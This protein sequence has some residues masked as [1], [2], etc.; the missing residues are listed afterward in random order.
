MLPHE[1]N[2]PKLSD[3][4]DYIRRAVDAGIDM[5]Q[6]RERDLAARDLLFVADAARAIAKE[7]NTLILVNDRSDVAAC[8]GAGVHLTTRSMKAD[9]VRRAFGISMPLGVSTHSLEEADE[10]EQRGADFI[11]FGPVFET[12]SKK[13]YGSPVGLDALAAVT[14]RVKIPVLA[15]GGINLG[16][17]RETLDR[18]AA[19]V[20]GIS[21]FAQA[22]DLTSVIRAIKV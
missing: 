4:I 10:A 8:A 2:N 20:A 19:G 3:L 21:L 14:A 22:E 18:G 12:E 16:N 17:F 15:I 11:V 13:V 6:I 5:V 9:V 1:K 7:R